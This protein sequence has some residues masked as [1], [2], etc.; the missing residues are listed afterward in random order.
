MSAS[1]L[2]RRRDLGDVLRAFWRANLVEE[3]QYRAN[4]VAS[5]VGTIFWMSAALLTLELFFSH[6]ER[7]G[8]WDYW[9][10][11]VLLG[12][13]NALNGVIETVLRPGIGRL[14]DEVKSGGLDLILVRPVDAQFFMT[15]RRLDVWRIADIVLGLALAGYALIR[16]DRIPSVG[17][18]A[19]FAAMMVS[20]VIVVYAIWLTLMSLAFWFVAVENIAV[21]F[22]AVFEAA[23]YPVSAYPGVLRFL[24]VYL[25]PI[26]WTTTIPASALTGR[27]HTGTALLSLAVGVLSFMASRAVW[28]AAM[29][30]YASAGG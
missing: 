15:F 3:M 7:L 14:A 20:A 24:F 28:R 21:L 23:R 5:V 13:F 30:R 17:A 12:V 22:D 29:R 2:E 4:F 16:M 18:I 9:E 26:A 10:V 11:V 25:L 6:T 8:G 1:R 27:L 19:T